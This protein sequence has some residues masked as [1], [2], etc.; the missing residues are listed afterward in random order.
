MPSAPIE[1]CAIEPP[2][3]VPASQG[4]KVLMVTTVQGQG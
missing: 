3:Y 2:E 1:A 4:L